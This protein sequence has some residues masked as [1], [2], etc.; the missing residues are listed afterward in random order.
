MAQPVATDMKTALLVID[1][2]L[3]MFNGE[4]IAPIHAGATLL[5]RVK[6]LVAQ[7]RTLGVPIFFVRHGGGPGHLLENGTANWHIHPTVGPA[8]GEAIVDKRTP[9]SFHETILPTELAAVGAERLIVVG[10]QTEFCVDTTCRR[11]FSLGF[12]V[13]LVADA[14]STWDNATLTADQIIRH[15]NQTLS[16]WFV[17][18]VPFDGAPFSAV[19]ATTNNSASPREGRGR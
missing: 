4:G 17:H 3:G 15:T 11:A 19:G 8:P 12:D 9:D 16:E 18:L 7:A 6:A 5:A 2:Q 13:T 14:H 10:A 1:L